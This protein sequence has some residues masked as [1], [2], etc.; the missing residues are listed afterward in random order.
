MSFLLELYPNVYIFK[1]NGFGIRV[2]IAFI[3]LPTSDCFIKLFSA[4]TP[5]MGFNWSSCTI[6]AL[7]ILPNLC[8]KEYAL[9]I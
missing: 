6:C 7:A 3:D 2:E 5:L 9:T 4:S 8:G 1:A